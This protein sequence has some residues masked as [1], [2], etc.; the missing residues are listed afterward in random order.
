MNQEELIESGLYFAFKNADVNI[1]SKFDNID[2][3]MGCALLKI[4]GE[5]IELMDHKSIDR[6]RLNAFIRFLASSVNKRDLNLVMI[7]NTRDEGCKSD[8][9][10]VQFFK[11]EDSNCLCVPDTHLTG[12]YLDYKCED[13]KPFDK[14]IN[15]V[16][17][18]GSDTGEYPN[19][20]KN[21]RI[22]IANLFHEKFNIG[23][24]NYTRYGQK[25]LEH[26]N[27]DS[28]RIKKGF[29]SKED[30][31]NYK[32]IA[33][34]NGNTV[35]WDRNMWAMGSNSILFKIYHHEDKRVFLWYSKYMTDKNIVPVLHSSEVETFVDSDNEDILNKQIEFSNLLNDKLTHVKFINRFI[36]RYNYE[37]NK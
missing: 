2:I 16:V 7:L 3:P 34:I 19:A 15:D 36:E 8:F 20:L 12:L 13:Q 5:N 31:L 37:Y 18:R 4:Q 11:Q 17:F 27:I 1:L 9:P 25:S 26:F 21:E 24:S 10:I 35:S 22:S 30:Q 14:K 32:Y 6:I 23:V 28:N 29:L 33:D